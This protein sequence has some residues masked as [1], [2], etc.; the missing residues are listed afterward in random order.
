MAFQS[1]GYKFNGK[2]R[3]VVLYYRED[4]GNNAG[5]VSGKPAGSSTQMMLSIRICKC[6]GVDAESQSRRQPFFTQD[7]TRSSCGSEGTSR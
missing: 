4:V 1:A 7:R 3:S 6:L 2:E 5:A